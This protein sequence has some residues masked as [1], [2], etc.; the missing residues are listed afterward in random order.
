MNRSIDT[1]FHVGIFVPGMGMALALLGDWFPEA[2]LI[3][4]A[5]CGSAAIGLARM[6]VRSSAPITPAK[7]DPNCP[8]F[9]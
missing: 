3:C 5:W 4:Q 1:Y 8:K 2:W 6:A 7:L 9:L